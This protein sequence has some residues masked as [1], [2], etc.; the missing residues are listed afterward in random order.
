MK[1][2]RV[3]WLSSTAAGAISYISSGS[4]IFGGQ[5]LAFT[6]HP[7]LPPD[8]VRSITLSGTGTDLSG[9]TFTL[10]GE[11]ETGAPVTENLA[12]PTANVTVTSVSVY[13]K[14]ISIVPNGS[15]AGTVQIG[16]GD[17]ANSYV[18]PYVCDVFNKQSMISVTFENFANAPVITPQG[19]ADVAGKY[20]QGQWVPAATRDWFPLIPTASSIA[21]VTPVVV[22]SQIQYLS[23]PQSSIRYAVSNAAGASFTVITIQ[24]GGKY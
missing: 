16:Y 3:D 14:I 13:A 23:W 9:I 10:T 15:S 8:N 11:T 22:A 21:Y 19:T 12:G 24:Q 6:N 17:N 7:N 4:P 20:I 1:P 2:Y 18:M 5:S